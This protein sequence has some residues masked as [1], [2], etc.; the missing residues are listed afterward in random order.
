MRADLTADYVEMGRWLLK[1]KT[2]VW[3]LHLLQ[4]LFSMEDIFSFLRGNISVSGGWETE[5]TTDT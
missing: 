1:G 4:F 3:L 5:E 2:C